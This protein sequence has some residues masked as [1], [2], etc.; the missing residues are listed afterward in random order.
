MDLTGADVAARRGWIARQF[1]LSREFCW[2]GGS[3]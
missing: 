2:S 1:K 3:T